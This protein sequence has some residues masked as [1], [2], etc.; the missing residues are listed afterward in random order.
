MY[1]L[2]GASILLF[3]ATL[4]GVMWT[5]NS[6]LYYVENRGP[7]DYEMSRRHRKRPNKRE[8]RRNKR[9]T[10]KRRYSDDESEESYSDDDSYEY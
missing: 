5:K 10:R 4:Y 2:I 3:C 9:D 7:S 6:I 1:D 8:R